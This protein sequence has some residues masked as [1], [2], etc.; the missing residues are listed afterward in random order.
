VTEPASDSATRPSDVP[1][2]VAAFLLIIGFTFS[3]DAVEFFLDVS[4]HPDF[5]AKG[6]LVLAL[7]CLL[8]AGTGALK[9]RITGG[10]S[11]LTTFLRGLFS[12]WWAAGAALV[13]VGHLLLIAT[14]EQRASLGDTASVWVNLLA[15]LVFT[16]A[17]T[18][19]LLSALSDGSDSRSWV[20]PLVIGTLAVAVATEL[21]APVIDINESCASDVSAQYFSDVA[22]ALVVILLALGVEMGYVRRSATALDPGRRVA[23]VFTVLMLGIGL[24]LSLTMQV[25]AGTPR[26]GLGAV[27]LQYFSFVVSVQAVAIGLA[28]LMWLMVTDAVNG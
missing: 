6:W 19:L 7:D 28:T 18:L 13:V 17:M 15:A 11:N 26:C 5:A 14:E 10:D 4:G 25:S 2:L 1:A 23:P 27:W 8:V 24:A 9:W 22:N 12:G 3:D 16:A 20:M 21:W